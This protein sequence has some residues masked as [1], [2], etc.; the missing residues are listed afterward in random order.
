MN[1]LDW[2]RVLGVQGEE[3]DKALQLRSMLKELGAWDEIVERMEE[4]EEAEEVASLAPASMA[5]KK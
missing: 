2:A 1:R 5:G 3:I 4:A